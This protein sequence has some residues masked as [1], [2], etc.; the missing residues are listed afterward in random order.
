MKKII[1]AFANP[2]LNKKL[3]GEKEYEIIT[4]D[5]QYQEGVIEILEENSNIDG[6]ILNSFLPG[7]FDLYKFIYKIKEINHNLEIIII[8]EKKNEELKNFL[9]ANGITNILYNNEITIEELIKLIKKEKKQIPEEIS[10]EIKL[11]KEMILNNNIR[12]NKSIKEAKK[13]INKVIEI[14]K[15]NKISKIIVKNKINKKIKNKNNSIKIISVVGSAGVGK[16]IFTSILSKIIINQKIL[17]IDFDFINNNISTIF[18]TKK[19]PKELN[20]KIINNKINKGE[21]ALGELII[22]INNKL[23]LICGLEIFINNN[24]NIKKEEIK[25]I[26]KKVQEISKE[27]DLV[28]I[29][30]GSYNENNYLEEVLQCSDKGILLVEPNLLGIKKSKKLLE[31]YINK[32]KIDKEKI[33]VVFNKANINSINNLILKQLF[34]D[35]NILGNIRLNLKYDLLINNNLKIQDKKIHKEYLKIIKKLNIKEEIKDGYELIG[36]E[37]QLSK[38]KNAYQSNE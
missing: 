22:K 18:S 21:K 29:D 23:N 30:T 13:I 9:F 5:I 37:Q 11:L 33:N 12:K 20:E 38:Y 4:P 15:S 16:S 1:T 31:T 14:F 3:L 10:E 27:Y 35:F 19:I 24:K 7:E 2:E 6:L 36:N 34:F 32:L 17:L 26:I 8:L 25:N 28:I